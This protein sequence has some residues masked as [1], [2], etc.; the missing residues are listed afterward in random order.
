M[1]FLI[2][3]ENQIRDLADLEN[4]LDLEYLSI[5]RNNILDVKPLLGLSKLKVLGLNNNLEN[6]DL[7]GN[8]HSK[9]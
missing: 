2:L 5:D 1:E 6:L 7:T 3:R 9:S 8:P 4:M